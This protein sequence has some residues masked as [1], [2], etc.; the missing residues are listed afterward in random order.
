LHKGAGWSVGTNQNHSAKNKINTPGRTWAYLKTKN[1]KIDT[2]TGEYRVFA[3]T[4]VM[5][6]IKKRGTT[7]IGLSH[8]DI[9]FGF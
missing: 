1:N 5:A 3:Q 2:K 7:D 9:R 6:N 8:I 4:L